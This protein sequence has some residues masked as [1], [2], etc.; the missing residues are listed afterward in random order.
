MSLVWSVFMLLFRAW[1]VMLGFGYLHEHLIPTL[2]PISYVVALVLTITV[3]ALFSNIL[4]AETEVIDYRD[5]RRR[6][7]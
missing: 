2:P 7:D 6:R 3:S 5:L 1:I 4:V